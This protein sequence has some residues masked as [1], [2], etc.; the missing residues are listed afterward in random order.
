MIYCITKSSVNL[1]KNNP[2]QNAIISLYMNTHI[3]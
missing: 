1:A 2:K 3:N